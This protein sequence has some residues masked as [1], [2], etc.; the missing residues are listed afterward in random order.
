MKAEILNYNLVENIWFTVALSS[1]PRGAYIT[2]YIHYPICIIQII[3]LSNSKTAKTPSIRWQDHT[4]FLFKF[5]SIEDAISLQQAH[6]VESVFL[7]FKFITILYVEALHN[8]PLSLGSDMTLIYHNGLHHFVESKGA[9]CS[10]GT[11]KFVQQLKLM[12]PKI[13][14]SLPKYTNAILHY[15]L[16]SQFSVPIHRGINIRSKRWEGTLFL[17]GTLIKYC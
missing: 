7:Q 6:M 12:I 13:D 16:T 17:W 3:V 11:Q 4:Q 5:D 10:K 9:F 15:N 2:L 8:S 1:L 14:S